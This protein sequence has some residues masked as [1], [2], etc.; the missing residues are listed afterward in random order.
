MPY[1]G[2]RMP[3]TRLTGPQMSNLRSLL[4]WWAVTLPCA[5][6]LV[7]LIRLA[8]PLE[9]SKPAWVEAAATAMLALIAFFTI[10][11]NIQQH[12]TTRSC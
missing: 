11:L 5:G 12:R 2:T 8:V 7:P 4:I 10:R 3:S 1:P 9:L 6:L